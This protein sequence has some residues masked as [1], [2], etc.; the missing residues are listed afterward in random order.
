MLVPCR[1][2]SVG[3]ICVAGIV[4][5]PPRKEPGNATTPESPAERAARLPPI[6][7][8]DWRKEPAKRSTKWLSTLARHPPTPRSDERTVG[9][10]CLTTGNPRLTH[11]HYT[12]NQPT[13]NKE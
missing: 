9:H 8:A 12:K 5:F 3:G 2:L 1:T 7:I 4:A 11:H 6:S 13:T 10:E